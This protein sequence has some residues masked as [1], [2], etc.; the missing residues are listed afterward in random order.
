MNAA[1]K[2]AAAGTHLRIAQ[3]TLFVSPTAAGT[4]IVS[5]GFPNEKQMSVAIKA[6]LDLI[7]EGDDAA[8]AAKAAAKEGLVKAIRANEPCLSIGVDPATGHPNSQDWALLSAH[9]DAVDGK[10]LV[11]GGSYRRLKTGTRGQYWQTVCRTPKALID[12]AM[13]LMGYAPTP[14]PK[15]VYGN[16]GGNTWQPAGAP[17]SSYAVAPGFVPQGPQGGET[18]SAVEDVSGAE[19]FG[20]GT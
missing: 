4:R 3:E 10:R 14:A 2:G 12:A 20:L 16:P 19:D 8:K 15:P 9:P 17:L 1:P 11:V 13:R 7:P 5:L 6:V 18:D